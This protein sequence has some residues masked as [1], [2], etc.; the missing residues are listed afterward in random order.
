MK[1]GLEPFVFKTLE[2]SHFDSVAIGVIDFENWTFESR[3]FTRSSEQQD[4]DK[5]YFDLASLT[6]PLTLGLSYLV[7]PEIYTD[8]MILLLEHRAGLPALGRLSKKTWKEQI[9][10]YQI[11]ESDVHYSDFSALRLQLEIERVSKKPIYEMISPY[12]DSELKN[13]LDLK[14]ENCLPT[15]QRLKK[16]IC[17]QVHDDNAFVIGERVS[18]AGLFSTVSGLCQT[19]INIDKEFNLVKNMSGEYPHRFNKGFDTV[20]DPKNSLAGPISSSSTFGHLGFTGTSFWIYPHLNKGIVV[21]TNET[22]KFWYDRKVLNSFRK[23]VV[24]FL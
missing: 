10:S 15:G 19:L 16:L 2:K 5:H 4:L 18:H 7:L 13:W 23:E 14:D 24:T 6:K 3:F 11:K 17:G 20:T 1:E 21:L 8:E 22:I 9:L 12:F